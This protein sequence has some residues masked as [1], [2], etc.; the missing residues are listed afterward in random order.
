M[1]DFAA[2]FFTIHA[3]RPQEWSK[4]SKMGSSWEDIDRFGNWEGNYPS[5]RPRDAVTAHVDWVSVRV[6]VCVYGCMSFC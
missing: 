1:S 3:Y 5:Q 4:I 2:S 6:C